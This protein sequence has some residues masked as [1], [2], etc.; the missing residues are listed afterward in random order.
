MLLFVCLGKK[1]FR[2]TLD[3]LSRLLYGRSYCHW[4]CCRGRRCS[5]L[6]RRL[7]LLAG[8]S[9]R[10]LTFDRYNRSTQQ[11]AL[12]YVAELQTLFGVSLPIRSFIYI[13]IF[14][15]SC[16]CAPVPAP[17]L[18][19][20]FIPSCC[21]LIRR[22]VWFY[23]FPSAPASPPNSQAKR[24][25]K[26][27]QNADTNLC[28]RIWEIRPGS[29][30]KFKDSF[31]FQP[32]FAFGFSSFYYIKGYSCGAWVFATNTSPF[33]LGKIIAKNFYCLFVTF[34]LSLPRQQWLAY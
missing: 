2:N 15:F 19:F 23:L 1:S 8:N 22:Y 32:R 10:V 30:A 25:H 24:V 18:A 6:L 34:E 9:F 7:Y 3:S 14:Y 16:M 4:S 21:G 5:F 17:P 12:L 26:D 13:N 28:R 33:V 20:H 11:F 29:K 31:P 27:F